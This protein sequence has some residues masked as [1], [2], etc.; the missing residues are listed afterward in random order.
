MQ[1]SGIDQFSY[2]EVAVTNTQLTITPRT[3]PATR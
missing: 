2:G 1:C 3:S